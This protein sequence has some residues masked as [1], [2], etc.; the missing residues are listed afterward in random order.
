M[1]AIP[2]SRTQGSAVQIKLSLMNVAVRGQQK[3]Y[4]LASGT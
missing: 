1:C 4:L 2:L 3:G